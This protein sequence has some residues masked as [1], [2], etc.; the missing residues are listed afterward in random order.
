MNSKDIYNKVYEELSIEEKDEKKK[1]QE[2]I[3]A[4]FKKIVECVSQ[5]ENVK[6]KDFGTFKMKISKARTMI[7]PFTK[8][9]KHIPEKKKLKFLPASKLE[10]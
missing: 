8:E 3:E 10:L 4:A 7:I 6:I 2:V 1:A 9:E 5:G